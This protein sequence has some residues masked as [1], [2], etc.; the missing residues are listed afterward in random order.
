MPPPNFFSWCSRTER[1]EYVHNATGGGSGDQAIRR[2]PDA[3]EN[4]RL[5]III[6]VPNG[7]CDQA[8]TWIVADTQLY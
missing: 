4:P 6:N 2:N 7:C 3:P 1:E 8:I 5:A